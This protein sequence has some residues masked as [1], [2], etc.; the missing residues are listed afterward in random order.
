MK[1]LTEELMKEG[2]SRAKDAASLSPA[3]KRKVG[4]AILM[5]VNSK[6]LWVSG[7][8][9]LQTRHTVNTVWSD[10]DLPC[11]DEQGNTLPSTPL[12]RVMHAEHHAVAQVHCNNYSFSKVIAVFVTHPPCAECKLHLNTLGGTFP[13]YIVEDFLKFD[14][15]KLRYELLPVLAV[16]EVVKVLTFGAKKYKPNNWRRVDDLDR[17]MGAALRHIAAHQKG[18]IYD[19]ETKCA[20]LGHAATNLL[21]LTELLKEKENA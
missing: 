20:H 15:D 19:P 13:I 11:E 16:E 3:N 17:Y 10:T 21:F 6:L 7:Y 18:E 9:H 2:Y 14:K 1:Q 12:K 8:N 5:E 4:C